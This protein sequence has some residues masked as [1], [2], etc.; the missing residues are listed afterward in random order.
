MTMHFLE[1]NIFCNSMQS[2]IIGLLH[3]QCFL[4]VK[5]Y[6]LIC[7]HTNYTIANA[8]QTDAGTYTVTVT[9]KDTENFV[10]N[11]KTDAAKEFPFVIAPAKVTVTFKY[12]SA[13][14]GSK[15]APDLS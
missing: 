7:L 13:Y 8:E 14:V 4:N 3:C 6:N 5:V 10:W 1:C 12:K 11:D 15:T 2:F 9:L